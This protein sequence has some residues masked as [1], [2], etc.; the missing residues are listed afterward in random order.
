MY[1]PPKSEDFLWTGAHFQLGKLKKVATLEHGPLWSSTWQDNRVSMGKLGH[2]F[3]QSMESGKC[4]SKS[5]APPHLRARAASQDG[6]LGWG[7]E[8]CSSTAPSHLPF[9]LSAC[10]QIPE[11]P[12]PSRIPNKHRACRPAGLS[13]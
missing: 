7:I 2:K 12:S 3:E 4:D 8:S 1:S 13:C 5:S 6:K 11:M 10:L 9:T